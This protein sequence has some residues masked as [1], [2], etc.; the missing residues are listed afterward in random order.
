RTG[1][2]EPASAEKGRRGGAIIVKVKRVSLWLN[3]EV[4]GR[5][6]LLLEARESSAEIFKYHHSDGSVSNYSIALGSASLT[7]LGTKHSRWRSL[8]CPSLDST[9][10]PQ[11]VRL[12]IV[13]DSRQGVEFP[14]S[15]NLV[16]QSCTV[17]YLNQT[18]LE[19]LDYL[20]NGV[21][22]DGPWC[23]WLLIPQPEDDH[24]VHER[25][26]PP[27]P[28]A[29]KKKSIRIKAS[30]AEVRLPAGHAGA[31]WVTFDA[32]TLTATNR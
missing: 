31:S 19:T 11:E 28:P 9:L 23:P 4:H 1:A 29:L 10:P 6:L 8:V 26:L 5:R 30:D 22:G 21:L 2:A 18:W 16:L 3:K 12:D 13:Q 27:P 15:V 32:K 20:M 24:S 14:I 25:V 17:N 7:D